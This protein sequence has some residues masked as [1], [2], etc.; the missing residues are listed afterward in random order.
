MDARRQLLLRRFI[1]TGDPYDAAAFAN[2]AYRSG[3]AQEIEVWVVYKTPPK[4]FI[5]TVHDSEEKAYERAVVLMNRILIDELGGQTYE[6]LLVDVANSDLQDELQSELEEFA[7]NLGQ[8]YEALARGSHKDA[9]EL[10]Q[11]G[12]M[13]NQ[14]IIV[15]EEIVD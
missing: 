9:I 14:R 3:D 6:E 1:E 15:R 4:G 8:I 5:I 13:S 12:P 10:Y 7:E 11:E 2:A